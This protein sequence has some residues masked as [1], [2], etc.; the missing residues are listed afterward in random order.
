MKGFTQSFIL[1]AAA[2][3][4]LLLTLHKLSHAIKV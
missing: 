3:A 1:I 2:A 4:A